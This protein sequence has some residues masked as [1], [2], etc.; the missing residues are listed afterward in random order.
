VLYVF[1]YIYTLHVCMYVSSYIQYHIHVAHVHL[2]Y[3]VHVVCVYMYV[4]SMHGM[5]VHVCNYN[6]C[7]THVNTCLCIV[8]CAP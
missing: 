7:G 6:V 2:W 4:C 1:I 3:V 5:H 8:T